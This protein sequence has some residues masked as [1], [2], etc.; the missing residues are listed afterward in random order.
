MVQQHAIFVDAGFLL[1]VGG[2]QVSGT[3]LRSASQ[4]RYEKLI[5]GIASC[6][7]AHAKSELLRTYWYDASK[8]AQYTFQH[9]QIGLLPDVKVRLGRTSYTGEQ[10]GVDLKLGLDLVGVARNSA[11]S[12]AYLL[13]GDDDLAEAVEAAQDLGMKVVLI[14]IGDPNKRLGVTS[15]AEH[16]ALQVDSIIA[17]PESLIDSCFLRVV[18]EEPRP[19]EAVSSGATPLIMNPPKPGAV[20]SGTRAPGDHGNLIAARPAPKPGPPSRPLTYEPPNF[21]HEEPPRVVYSSG[22]GQESHG[23][24]EESLMDVAESVGHSVAISWYGSVTQ[25]DVNEILGERP[26]LPA[27]IDR[28]LLKDCA[29]RIGEYKTDLQGIRKELR[30]AFWRKVDVLTGG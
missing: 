15:V 8:D 18:G 10:K 4:V 13:S 6:A 25:A 28:V 17:L 2:T 26:L 27:E 11:A 29:A 9:K 24:M 22:S 14:G 5:E 16:L 30:A 1:A 20:P 7:S 12:V 3:S 19:V 21:V 23:H